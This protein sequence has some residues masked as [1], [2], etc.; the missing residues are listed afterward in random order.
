MA[1]NNESRVLV[2]LKCSE[3]KNAN[4]RVQKNVKNTTEKLVLNKYC[5]TCRKTTEH[6]ESNK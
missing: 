5:N 4:Y 3:C 2:T 1:K 6:K